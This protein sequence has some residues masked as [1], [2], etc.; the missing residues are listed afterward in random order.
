VPKS[1]SARI[2]VYLYPRTSV[3][4][5]GLLQ[6]QGDVAKRTP[7]ARIEEVRFGGSKR[8]RSNPHPVGLD[9]FAGRIPWIGQGYYPIPW[10]KL[11]YEAS[12]GGVRAEITE[13]QIK[14]P[15]KLKSDARLGLDPT[16]R[17]S[18]LTL[19]RRTVP[20]ERGY[21]RRP[22]SPIGA[23]KRACRVQVAE[24][25]RCIETLRDRHSRRQTREVQPVR[26][27]RGDSTA[28]Q[29]RLRRRQD[30]D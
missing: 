3:G 10:S 16:G 27:R 9:R 20:M 22:K 14:A 18:C 11:K 15:T 29:A 19:S 2:V 8:I 17:S 4:L 13:V 21:P 28:R 26:M 5:A 23:R 7:A 30:T 25:K 12:P 24:P 1:L 6:R